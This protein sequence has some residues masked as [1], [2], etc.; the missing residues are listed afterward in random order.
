V[1]P[2]QL[3]RT[4]FRAKDE[5]RPQLLGDVFASD[6]RLEVNDRS[7]QVGFP[8]VTIG[9][10]GISEVLVRRFNQTY[11]NIRSFYLDRPEPMVE[12]FTCD[13]LVGM[14][15]KASGN[16][17]VGCG[18]YEWAFANRPV[19]RVS[20]LVIT[21]EQMVVLAPTCTPEVMRSLLMLDYP[22]TSA[23]P[24]TRVLSLG[25]L[26][27]VNEYIARKTAID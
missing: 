9:L 22:W 23:G 19:L 6:A 21:I 11:G 5:N 17:R 13:W 24:V 1:S 26:G 25:E 27:S 16:V 4:Y 12:A 7:H 20:K 15:E 10:E 18:Q 3:L 8:A 14:T 2:E